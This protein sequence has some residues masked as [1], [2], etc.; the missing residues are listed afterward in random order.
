[1]DTN[2]CQVFWSDDDGGYIAVSPAFPRLSGFGKT[3]EAALAE[4]R[5]V[6]K[7]A[8][9]LYRESGWPLPAGVE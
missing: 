8:V 4:L 5:G 1:M 9:V 2:G 7:E 3:A 6:L